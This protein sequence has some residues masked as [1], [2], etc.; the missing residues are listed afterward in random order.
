[1]IEKFLKCIIFGI[2][3][4]IFFSLALTPASTQDDKYW[5]EEV[6]I[7]RALLL[8]LYLNAMHRE[9][10]PILLARGTCIFEVKEEKIIIHINASK[11]V[12]PENITILKSK[13]EIEIF[14]ILN[15]LKMK[16]IKTEFKISYY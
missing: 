9:N 14:Q 1:M 8:E 13:V 2:C 3:L 12:A 7:S 5:I 15:K 16:F 4:L 11:N 10:I 6:K